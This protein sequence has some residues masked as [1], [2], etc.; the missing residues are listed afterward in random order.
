MVN[1]LGHNFLL[2]EICMR[3]IISDTLETSLNC[4]S[5]KDRVCIC[6]FPTMYPVILPITSKPLQHVIIGLK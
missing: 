5:N 3:K 1:T 4:N 2:H 6:H